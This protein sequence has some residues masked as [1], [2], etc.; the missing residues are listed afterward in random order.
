MEYLVDF[1]NHDHFPFIGRSVEQQRL[2]TFWR[3][4]IETQELRA[5]M[6]VGEAG[7]GKSRL[8][9]ET[10]PSI[11]AAGGTVVRARLF[12]ESGAS[13]TT[14]IAEALWYNE[15]V[16][17][18]FHTESE[19]T[20]HA[21]V[22]RLRR[23]SRLRPTLVIID[24]L[25]VMS[26]ETARELASILEPL[27]EE[28]L[29]VVC[30]A[31]PVDLP[32]RG[33]IERFV[34]EEILLENLPASQLAQL[35]ALLFGHPP[36][37]ETIE[38]LHAAT[39]G[40]LLTVRSALRGAFTA[41]I[42][43][44]DPV[45][46]RWVPVAGNDAFAISLNRSVELLADGMT[47]GLT[48]EERAAAAQLAALGEVFAHET[49]RAVLPAADP[50]IDRL[51][52]RGILARV[53]TATPPLPGQSSRE[54]LLGFTHSVLHQHLRE[55]ASF[56]ANALAEAIADG[57]P[58]YSIQPLLR[59]VEKTAPGDIAAET[60]VGVVERLL[61]TARALDLGPSWGEAL[62]ILDAAD[63]LFRR[64]R[65][66]WA[67]MD[68]TLMQARLVGRRLSLMRRT[69]ATPEYRD[70]VQSLMDLTEGRAQPALLE[71]RMWAFRYQYVHHATSNYQACRAVWEQAELLVATHPELRC[72][73]A[74]V[75][76]LG[77]VAAVAARQPDTEQLAEAEIRLREILGSPDLADDLRREAI[78][79][80][81][82]RFLL[83]FDSSEELA[84]RMRFLADLLAGSTTPNIQLISYRIMLLEIT[85]QYT[86]ALAACES[87][88]ELLERRGLDRN[89]FQ[90]QLT[91]ICARA[92]LGEELDA[93]ANEAWKLCSAAPHDRAD[94]YRRT[95]SIYLCEIGLLRGEYTW[96]AQVAQRFYPAVPG[97]GGIGDLLAA[98]ATNTEV[99]ALESL[100]ADDIDDDNDRAIAETARGLVRTSPPCDPETVIAAGQL[101]ARPIVRTSELLGVSALAA[102][103]MRSSHAE[104]LADTV[105]SAIQQALTWLA[106]RNLGLFMLPIVERFEAELGRRD[107]AFWRSEARRLVAEHGNRTTGNDAAR[108]RITM[109]GTIGVQHPDGSEQHLRGA[110]L[111]TVLG[112]LVA[113]RLM[114]TPL[115]NAEFCRFA[116]G[117]ELDIDL[118]RKTANM[119]IVRLRESIGAELIVTGPE[120]YALN[121]DLV[122]VDILEAHA[123]LLEAEV[124]LRRRALML[125]H[126]ATLAALRCSRGEVPFPG[127][128]DNFFEAIR[129]DFENRLRRTVI[130]VAKALLLAADAVGASELLRRAVEIMPDDEELVDLLCDA[131]ERMGQRAEASRVRMRASDEQRA[132]A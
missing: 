65:S 120:T 9:E 83:L 95:C 74:Y 103:A 72:T 80:I 121:M 7:T 10:I 41:G 39:A 93:V 85:G 38:T 24:D 34:A 111:K 55:A 79:E 118:A 62:R 26:R 117:G 82:P 98:L 23:L 105:R 22:G 81:A 89:L 53:T 128:Y 73:R 106:E 119:A 108:T 4:T 13:I 42:L 78:G 102:V 87:G 66:A 12:Q 8:L 49:A 47:A 100:Q 36:L 1:L 77:A 21:V 107:A 29:A 15:E 32:A 43:A 58:L 31:R 3:N 130:D 16:R 125:A 40:N 76:L 112:L 5:L 6:I 44:A 56:P 64:T 129:E 11:A 14:I 28:A 50:M 116:A 123:L 110:R 19:V 46:G 109:L 54:P 52:F 96:A 68:A 86:E 94:D 101:I 45:T 126:P 18:L 132:E 124:A 113:A 20:P 60:V 70:L 75:K 35:W 30:T 92:A 37:P 97:L 51:L 48:T 27:S 71:Q 33:V 57:L 90:C 91:R 127:L 61:T 88:L 115:T 63:T 17:R 131:L 2:R 84:E 59:I 122:S 67:E 99:A 104:A 114:N 25:H 69:S